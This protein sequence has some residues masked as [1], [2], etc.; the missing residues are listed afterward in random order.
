MLKVA[1]RTSFVIG[2]G[3]RITEI[4]SGLRALNPAVTLEAC[5]RS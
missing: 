1:K 2:K 4:V 3:G 5:A